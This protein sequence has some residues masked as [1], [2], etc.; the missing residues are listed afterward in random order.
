MTTDRA[1]RMAAWE[2]KATAARAEVYREMST[3]FLRTQISSYA[4]VTA[5]LSARGWD[6]KTIA[7]GHEDINEMISELER[8]G[9]L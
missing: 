6:P 3:E 9:A 8:R 2:E 4:A 7:I 5:K 1:D